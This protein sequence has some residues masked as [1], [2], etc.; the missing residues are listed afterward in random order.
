MGGRNFFSGVENNQ[1][2][3]ERGVH[4]YVQNFN[5]Q[6]KPYWFFPLF[7][8]SLKYSCEW[9]CGQGSSAQW[10]K[11]KKSTWIKHHYQAAPFYILLSDQQL[12]VA[13]ICWP[14]KFDTLQYPVEV[15]FPRFQSKAARVPWTVFLL[16]LSLKYKLEISIRT[17]HR[18]TFPRFPLFL[19][20]FAASS[21]EYEL[22]HR[23]DLQ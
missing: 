8:T 18:L 14:K 1:R 13:N 16:R 4:L 21:Q 20:E 2:G 3:L 22:V 15:R 17:M 9:R 12:S 7:F 10:P 23:E 6:E 11:V 5:V 19:R